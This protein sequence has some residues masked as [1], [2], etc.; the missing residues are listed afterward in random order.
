MQDLGTLGGPDGFGQFVNNRV[1]AGFSYT[2]SNP[3]PLGIP[4]FDPFIWEKG[5]MA[6]VG[7][8]GGTQCNPY[9]LNSRGELVGNMNVSGDTSFHPFLWDGEKLTRPWNIRRSPRTSGVDQ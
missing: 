3:G 8:L 9:W 5:T 6:D 2:T 4:P 1:T 7:N